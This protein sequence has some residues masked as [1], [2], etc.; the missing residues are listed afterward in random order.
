MKP[1]RVLSLGAGVQSSTLALMMAAGEIEPVDHAIFADT[2]SEPRA[3]LDWLSV[4]EGLINQLPYAFP[5]HRVTAGDLKAKELQLRTSKGGRKYLGAKIPAF[6]LSPDGKSKG[7]M[8][9]KCTADFKITP[10]TQKV[11]QLLGLKR[12]LPKSG[13]LVLQAIGISRD[14]AHRMK[15]SRTPWIESYWPLIDAK[16][17]REDCLKW[18]ADHGYPEPPRSSCTFCPF[19]SDA[20]WQRQTPEDFQA[21]VQFERDLQ[22]LIPLQDVLRGTPY[23]HSSCVPLDQVQWREAKGREQLSLFGNECEG[24]CGV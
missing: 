16:M 22:A 2:Q 4:L 18:M 6:V 8:G 21:A 1:L 20:E 17:T 9:R 14:E 24:L 15:P 5:V 13:I 23:L 19:H 7:L 11:R 3:V 10:V 12:V